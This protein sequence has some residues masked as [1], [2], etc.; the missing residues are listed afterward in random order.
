M[1]LIDKNLYYVGGV[2]RDEILGLESFDIDLCYE[3]NAIDFAQTL[4]VIKTNPDFGTVRVV[5]ED[6][7]IDIASTRCESYPKKGHLPVVNNIGCSLKED[8]SRRD[9]T[10]N[11]LAKNTVSGEIVDFFDGLGDLKDR[12][13]KVLH[14]KSFIDDPSRIIRGLKFAIRFDFELDSET[15][16]LQDEYLANINYDMSYHRIKKELKETF[17]LNS[18]NAYEKFVNENIYKLLG[19]NQTPKK[20]D[21][22]VEELIK[23]YNPESVWL[24]YMGLYDLSNFE[25]TTSEKSIVEAYEK[26]CNL[27][28]NTDYDVYKAFEEIPLEAVLMYG[29]SINYDVAINYLESISKIKIE[30]CGDDLQDLGIKPGK[31]YKEIFDYILRKKIETPSLDKEDE[32]NLVREKYL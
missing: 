27:K 16:K 14:D 28:F 6:K 8:L 24:I 15:K 29:I 11:A 19:E 21:S 13:L 10:I 2:V 17:N 3:G 31:V 4:D 1:K 22:R 23:R 12:K 30:I 18:Y 26:V 32:I 7:E 5:V 20:I 25:L 9:F